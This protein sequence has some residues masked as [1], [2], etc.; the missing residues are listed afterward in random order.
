MHCLSPLV[1]SGLGATVTSYLSRERTCNDQKCR[2]NAIAPLLT[3]FFLM[4]LDRASIIS[5]L[6]LEPRSLEAPLKI[7]HGASNASDP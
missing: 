2:L 6:R 5:Q 3:M 7:L 1:S 4:H